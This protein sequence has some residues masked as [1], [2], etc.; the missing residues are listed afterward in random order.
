VKENSVSGTL[1]QFGVTEPRVSHQHPNEIIALTLQPGAAPNNIDSP[2]HISQQNKNNHD[3]DVVGFQVLP[4]QGSGNFSFQIRVTDSKVL[5]YE[6]T[7]E[8][9]FYV[10]F[11][12][13]FIYRRI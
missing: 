5:D 10:S 2:H 7:K 3:Q 12:T 4:S 11:L 1:V 8:F 9:N 6:T 13:F